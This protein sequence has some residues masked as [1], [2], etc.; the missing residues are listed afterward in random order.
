MSALFSAVVVKAA[1][2]VISFLLAAPGPTSTSDTKS[3]VPFKVVT[4]K[5]VSAAQEKESTDTT[6]AKKSEKSEQTESAPVPKK[7]K[8]H[9]Q[10]W[11]RQ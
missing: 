11:C 6:K 4:I 9:C 10:N 2:F 1:V 7:E 3:H 8:K 5:A